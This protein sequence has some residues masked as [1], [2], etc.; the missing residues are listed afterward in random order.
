MG[1]RRSIGNSPTYGKRLAV[2]VNDNTWQLGTD[3][4]SR[5]SRLSTYVLLR[6]C[7]VTAIHRLGWPEVWSM[8]CMFK[9][10][11]ELPADMIEVSIRV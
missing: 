11:T 8:F 9:R 1:W 7:T 4:L 2:A 3:V 5:G 10:R 6:M